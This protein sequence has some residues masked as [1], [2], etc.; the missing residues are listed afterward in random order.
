MVD[1]LN[2]ELIHNL[3]N[4]YL[5]TDTSNTT[6]V[7]IELDDGEASPF[8]LPQTVSETNQANEYTN[9]QDNESSG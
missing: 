8:A 6:P 7:F 4:D 2:S 9:R 5:T 1:Q 3:Q